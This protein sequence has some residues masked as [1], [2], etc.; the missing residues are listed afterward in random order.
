MIS[1]TYTLR[2]ITWKPF[3]TYYWSNIASYNIIVA[4]EKQEHPCT[5]KMATEGKSFKQ[6]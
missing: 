3:L 2:W 5:K 1:Y 4:G 6:L